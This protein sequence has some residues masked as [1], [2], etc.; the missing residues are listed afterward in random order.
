MKIKELILSTAV[1]FALSACGGGSSDSSTTDKD[2]KDI[3]TTKKAVVEY[4]CETSKVFQGQTEKEKVGADGAFVASCDDEYATFKFSNDKNELN[5]VN[6]VVTT[7]G[8]DY[9]SKGQGISLTQETNLVDGT[10]H[11]FGSSTEYG[12]FDCVVTYD[13]GELP[14]TIY[15]AEDVYEYSGIDN[16]FQILNNKCPEWLVDE[17]DEEITEDKEVYTE[18]YTSTMSVTDSSG[19]VSNIVTYSSLK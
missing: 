5:I 1:V 14:K 16:E 19:L 10:V 7:T 6:L 15:D 2:D 13:F 4:D 9:N 18:E 8:E 17:E 3:D 12:N 11:I